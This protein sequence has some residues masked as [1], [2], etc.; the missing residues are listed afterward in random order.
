VALAIETARQRF[1]G[2]RL[3]AVFQPTLYT[4]LQRFLKP[5]SEA[6]DRADVVVVVEIQPS[7]EVDTGLIHGTALVD[8]V[9]KRPA[10]TEKRESVYYGG[11]YAETA[12]L[13]RALRQPGDVTVV[14]GSGPV[15]Q[16]ISFARASQP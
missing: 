15:N 16:V 1:P 3:I 13:L 12:E 4:R 11:T 9:A 2:R 8:E 10:F 6:F 7:R 14:M 5:F